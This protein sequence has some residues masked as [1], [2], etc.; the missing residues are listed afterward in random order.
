MIKPKSDNNQATFWSTF[1][2]QLDKKHPLFALA[3]KINWSKFE[4]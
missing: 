4:E 2:E 1:E 3:N